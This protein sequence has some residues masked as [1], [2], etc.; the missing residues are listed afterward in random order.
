[1]LFISDCKIV[2]FKGAQAVFARWADV[3][4][5]LFIMFPMSL[6]AA[7]ILPGTARGQ[8]CGEAIHQSEVLTGFTT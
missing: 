4:D 6:R 2:F 8:V 7:L 5:S 3:D 1:M